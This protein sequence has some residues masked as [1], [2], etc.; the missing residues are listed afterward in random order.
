MQT[1]QD[2]NRDSGVAAYEIGDDFIV[3]RFKGNSEYLYTY[4][5]AGSGNIERMKILA[6]NG[7]G[8]NS[9]IMKNVKDKYARKLN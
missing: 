4:E 8:L 5:S 1:Y 9:F 6:K 7:D 3:V 2:I